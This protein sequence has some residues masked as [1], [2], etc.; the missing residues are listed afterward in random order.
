[1]P[2]SVL[3]IWGFPL[4]C[5]SGILI[6]IGLLP[7]RRLCRLERKPYEIVAVGDTHFQFF[8]DGILRFTVP[9]AAIESVSYYESGH[10]YGIKLWGN[11]DIGRYQAHSRKRY[12]CD[13]F[14]PYFSRYAFQSLV[15]FQDLKRNPCPC[16]NGEVQ[17]TQR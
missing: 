11:F 1:M 13:L 16:S 6:V 7:Y 3:N 9:R 8:S 5:L 4:F 2:V 14:L 17:E 15:D 10:E 12:G